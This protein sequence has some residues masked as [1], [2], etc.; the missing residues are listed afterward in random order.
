MAVPPILRDS[1]AALQIPRPVHPVLRD[2]MVVLQIPR[3]N[4]A[5]LPMVKL[6]HLV[7]RDRMAV[8]P[9]V[10]RPVPVRREALVRTAPREALARDVR[11]AA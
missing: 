10:P 2:S 1:M 4:S 7:L 8:L 3:D 5:V 9:V 11:K 6:V